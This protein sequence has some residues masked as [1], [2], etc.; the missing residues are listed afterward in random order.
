[1]LDST[2]HALQVNENYKYKIRYLTHF[3]PER[4]CMLEIILY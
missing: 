3:I 4:E 2:L 1:M